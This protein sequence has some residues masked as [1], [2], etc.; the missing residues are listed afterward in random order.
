MTH[1]WVICAKFFYCLPYQL[2]LWWRL[3]PLLHHFVQRA[4]ISKR[5]AFWSF[6]EGFIIVIRQDE[7][8][9]GVAPIFCLGLSFAGGDQHQH[10]GEVG[11]LYHFLLGS[12]ITRFNGLGWAKR[13][14]DGQLCHIGQKM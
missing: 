1:I 7:F 12:I 14:P 2:I 13:L 4:D 8:A 5:P 6:A 10:K 9:T 11:Y 3:K